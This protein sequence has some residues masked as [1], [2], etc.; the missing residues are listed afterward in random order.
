[1]DTPENDSNEILTH[2]L[3]S[4]HQQQSVLGMARYLD[5]IAIW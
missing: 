3:M 1:M 2:G 4:L 5:S